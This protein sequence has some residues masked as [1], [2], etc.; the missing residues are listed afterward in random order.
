MRPL[1]SFKNAADLG[2]S[3]PKAIG[4]S[5]RLEDAS[6]VESSDFSDLIGGKFCPAVT[7]PPAV[8]HANSTP[9]STLA[10]IVQVG[11]WVQVSWI[12]ARRVV[13]SV[14]DEKPVRHIPIVAQHPSDLVSEQIC[15]VWPTAQTDE[16]IAK[17]MDTS[18]QPRPTLVRLAHFDPEPKAQAKGRGKDLLQNPVR[19]RLALH[20][21][22]RLICATASAAQTA[23]GHFLFSR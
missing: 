6:C 21:S 2:F 3:H 7:L 13:A 20:R 11:A 8:P 18:S 23:R 9:L 17:L 5:R 12:A 1:C 22:V 15:P 14:K 4:Q 10:H 19:G 16:A